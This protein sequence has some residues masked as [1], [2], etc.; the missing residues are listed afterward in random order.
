MSNTFSPK[1]ES[2]SFGCKR[3]VRPSKY[4]TVKHENCEYWQRIFNI[5]D[6]NANIV[7][8]I[9]KTKIDT[10]VVTFQPLHRKK[11]VIKKLF[12]SESNDRLLAK[13]VIDIL[14]VNDDERQ[15]PKFCECDLK[16]LQTPKLSLEKSSEIIQPSSQ[17]S[18]KSVVDSYSNWNDLPV[19]SKRLFQK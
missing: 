15:L 3:T 5:L 19:K 13:S 14:S 1:T 8:A 9:K 10:K 18:G 6:E 16:Y 4:E 17:D 12:S 11:A 7:S 2:V